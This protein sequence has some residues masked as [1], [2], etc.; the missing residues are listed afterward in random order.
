[1]Y[2]HHTIA[3]VL[4]AYNEADH[5]GDVIASLPSFVDR[6]YVVDDASTDGTWDEIREQ[7]AA[8]N[9]ESAGGDDLVVPLRH[10]VN[11]GAGGALKTGYRRALADGLELVVT[12]DADGQMDPDELDRLLD[13]L[14]EGRADYAKGDRLSRPA[15]RVSMPRFRL[16]GNAAL[17]LL[18]RVAS[19]YWRTSDPQ[20]GYTA[21]TRE[22]LAAVDVEEL[23]EYYGYCN[24][25]L[26]RLNAAG[27]CV[28]DVPMS[29]NYGDEKSHISLTAYV[30]KVAFMLLCGFLWRYR[31]KYLAGGVHPVGAYCV[32]G[33]IAGSLGVLSILPGVG[34][35]ALGATLLVIAVGGLATAMSLDRTESRPLEVTIE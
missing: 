15:D 25:M 5:V 6:M 7:A 9:D 1:M 24:E 13:P 20:N 26:I 34:S 3:V 19:G 21:I 14:V 30:P 8:L 4:P 33:V 27:L 10:D 23:Y 2:R 32:A 16:V 17:T 22:A 18:T 29:A 31:R 12:M 11:R 28:A 35:V